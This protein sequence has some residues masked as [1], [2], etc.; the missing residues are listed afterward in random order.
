MGTLPDGRV[1]SDDED[2]APKLAYVLKPLKSIAYQSA[3]YRISRRFPNFMRNAL[4]TMRAALAEAT[5][6]KSTSAKVQAVGRARLRQRRPVR[7]IR[8]GQA[9]S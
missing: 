4:M 9:T 2:A 8:N 7:T 5:T 6:S 3:V 1:A